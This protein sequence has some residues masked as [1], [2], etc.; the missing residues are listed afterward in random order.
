MYTI[1]WLTVL[2][3]ASAI[4]Q[5]FAIYIYIQ[6]IYNIV[7][8]CQVTPKAVLSGGQNVQRILLPNTTPIRPATTTVQIRPASTQ[9]VQGLPPGTT[10]LSNTG[11]IPGLQGFALVP[12]NYVA[13]VMHFHCLKWVYI[14]VWWISM[15]SQISTKVSVGR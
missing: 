5:L 8:C 4:L 15:I 7:L 11:N 9:N 14:Q 6:Y 10:I 2:Y 3:T 13:Q 1:Y 12:A